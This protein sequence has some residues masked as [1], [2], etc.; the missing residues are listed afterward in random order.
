[1]RLLVTTLAS[2]K[3]RW[4]LS[5]HEEGGQEVQISGYRNGRWV[6]RYLDRPFVDAG[7]YWITDWKSSEC[8]EGVEL[9]EFLCAIADQYRPKMEEYRSI[10][11]EAGIKLPVKLGLYL[12]S[13]DHFIEL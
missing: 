13:V 7:T 2:E 4:I 8:P 11:I 6:H 5:K 9:E 10:V 12:P 1:M 3:G